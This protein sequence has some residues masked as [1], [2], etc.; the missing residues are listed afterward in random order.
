MFIYLYNKNYII[1]TY[2]NNIYLYVTFLK[3]INIY[4]YVFSWIHLLSLLKNYKY[5]IIKE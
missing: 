5:K 4:L 2:N 3:I 1:Y